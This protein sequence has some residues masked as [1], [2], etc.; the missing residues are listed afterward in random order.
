[1]HEAPKPLFHRDIRWPNI[2][3]SPDH[4]SKWFLIDWD[5]AAISPTRAA[6]H[7]DPKSHSAAVFQDNHGAEVDIWAA[8]MLILNAREFVSAIPNTL[9][10]IGTQMVEGLIGTAT[11]ARSRIRQLTT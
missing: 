7:L 4:H 9:A 2:I 11:E 10:T 3:L 6:K 1:M 5:D 8:G